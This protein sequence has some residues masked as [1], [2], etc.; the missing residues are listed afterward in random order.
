MPVLESSQG[1][2]KVT[3]AGAVVWRLNP[4]LSHPVKAQTDTPQPR[5]E[6]IQVALV[7]R[8]R[9]DDWSWPKG[10]LEPGESLPATAAREVAEE[11]GK[12]ATLGIKLGTNEYRLPTGEWKAVHY[13]LAR[14]GVLKRASAARKLVKLADD[15]EIDQVKWVG[16]DEAYEL[17]SRRSD[18][19]LLDRLEDVHAQGAFTTRPVVLVRHGKAVKREKWL[20]EEPERP[21]TKR[22]FSQAHGL[23]DIFSAFGISTLMSSPWVR[24]WSTLDVYGQAARIAV[25]EKS[26]LT[27]KA[28][29]KH[30][31]LAVDLL[32]EQFILASQSRTEATNGKGPGGV[33]LC[34]HGPTLALLMDEALEFSHGVTAAAV[35]A[36]GPGREH[37]LR[38]GEALVL[39]VAQSP[40][41]TVPRIVGWERHVPP[42]QL[43]QL[44][45]GV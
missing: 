44:G 26:E 23:V 20:G 29:A 3:A 30:P 5:L 2:P 16:M 34:S 43:T 22:G 14:Q 37:W 13:W 9:Y 39:H 1:V 15:A 40:T 21:L 32:H 35:H 27:E 41:G 42:E 36:Q 11:I 10:K 31:G 7:H 12:Q 33:A 25:K 4:T 45:S 24:C 6:D 8:P 28:F 38:T 17:I 19:Q 18:R